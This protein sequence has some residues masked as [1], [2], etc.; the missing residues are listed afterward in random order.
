MKLRVVTLSLIIFGLCGVS[1]SQAKPKKQ[2]LVIGEQKG[3]RHQAVSHAMATIER[4]GEET[5]LWETTIRTDT[6]VLTK[7]KLEFNAKNLNDFDAVLFFTSG[8]LE[9]N[10]QQKSDLLSFVHDDGKGFIGVHSATITF[11]EWPEYGKMIG[12]YFDEHPWGTFEAP[13]IVED[14]AFPGMRQWPPSFV[15]R[16]EIYQLKDY[17]RDQLR[18][19]MRLDPSKLDLTNPHVHRTDRDF[20][21][22]WAKM[23]GKGRVYYS[24]L[25]HLKESWDN[26]QIQ[27]MFTEAIKWATGLL[28]ADV[29]PRPY[30]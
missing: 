10:A 15:L 20:A 23:Y 14:P 27:Q 21:V 24:S 4:M 17:S 7:R 9:M 11:T 6:E 25:G 26:P 19:L 30:P 2:L 29:T 3:Y 18:V 13:I 12:G 5:G 28:D 16:D 1:F 8:E 22:T